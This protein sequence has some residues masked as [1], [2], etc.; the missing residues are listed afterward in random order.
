MRL[1]ASHIFQALLDLADD[2]EIVS[3]LRK[4]KRCALA[5]GILRIGYMFAAVNSRCK[6]LGFQVA[7][8]GTPAQVI[9]RERFAFTG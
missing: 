2:E 7:Q 4:S 3:T 8:S 5:R 1:Q 6:R 9:P